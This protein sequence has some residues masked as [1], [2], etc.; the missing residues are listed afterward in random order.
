VLTRPA[1]AAVDPVTPDHPLWIVPR[2]TDAITIDGQLNEA[3]WSTAFPIVRTQAWRDDGRIVIRLLYSTSGA[4]Q[5][6]FVSASVQDENVWVDGSGGGTGNSWEVENDDSLLVYADPN[7]SRDEFMQGTD[8]C[9]GVNLGNM[10][11]PVNG[12]ARV[13]RVSF[14]MGDGAGGRPGIAAIPPGT[15]WASTIQGTI[16]D[17]T[18]D[19]GWTLEMFLPWATLD[20]AAPANGQTIGLNFDLIFDNDGGTRNF[21]SHVSDPLPDRIVLPAF[22]DDHEQGAQSSYSD[23]QAGVHGP[24]NYA[25]AMFFDAATISTPAAISDMS[26]FSPSA[27]GAKLRFSA[28]AGTT[29]GAGHVVGYEIRYAASPITNETEW[30][31]ATPIPNRYVPRLAT[32]AE[33]LRVPGLAP[34]TY[35]YFA[36]R[37]RDAAGRLGGLSN[38]AGVQTLAANGPGDRGRVIPSPLGSSL[39]YE[40]G[41]PFVV[42][43]EHLGLGWGYWRTLWPGDVWDPSSMQLLNFS[44]QTPFE[45]PAGPHLDAIAAEG[46]N[47]LRIFVEYLGAFSQAGAPAMP[48]GRYWTEFPRG[49]YNENAHQ[50]LLDVIAEAAARDIY[51]ILSP[52]DTF[53]YPGIFTSESPFYSGNCGVNGCGPLASLAT[54][55]QDPQMLDLVKD[56]YDQLIAWVQESP[57]ADHVLGWEP[58]NEWDSG[59]WAPSYPEPGRETEL[60]TRGAWVRALNSYVRDQDPDRMVISSSARRDPRGPGARALFYDRSLDVLAPHF[61]TNSSEEPVNNPDADTKVRPAVENATLTS[62]FLTHRLD[63]RPLLNGEWGMTNWKWPGGYAQ[64]SAAFTQQED[65]A[66][67]RTVSWSGLASGQIGTG[68]RIAG[69]EL[70]GPVRL[71]SLTPAMRQVQR[72]IAS[73]AAQGGFDWADFPLLTLEGQIAAT[74]ASKTLLAWGS[75]DGRQG[76]AYVLQDGNASSGTVS[77]GVLQIHGVAPAADYVVRFWDPAGGE[78]GEIAVQSDVVVGPDQTLSVTLPAFAE[79]VAVKFAPEPGAIALYVAAWLALRCVARRKR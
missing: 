33:S 58:M 68:L 1:S 8:R 64:Y 31:A 70:E 30:G 36:V 37:G 2:T 53:A 35:Y 76:L 59:Y 22:I 16:N 7:E 9:F 38:F 51:L 12:A 63:Q 73:F 72:T 26:A 69:T 71:N 61:Y 44:T 15:A 46:V 77:D 41:D 43:G 50:F 11:D 49:V 20:M 28:P 4:Q 62:Y 10:G 54:F 52:F 25:E 56:R 6:L 34:S 57:Y 39:I 14:S 23:S 67:Y 19:T 13:R 27:F 42:V 79:D 3:A 66:I 74:S 32:L 21:V 18:R 45:G 55:Y 60:R 65:E 47:V 48:I 17:G 5:G 75:T 24:I 40:N 29:G 78:S